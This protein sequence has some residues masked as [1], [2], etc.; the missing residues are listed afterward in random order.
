M[1][2]HVQ[3]P[4]LSAFQVAKITCDAWGVRNFEREVVD[5]FNHGFI[6]A[7]PTTLLLMKAVELQ[8]GRRA[9]HITH[10]I[11]NL[12]RLASLVPFPLEWIALRRRQDRR[13]RVYRMERF[14]EL[15]LRM[16][17]AKRKT[18]K[19]FRAALPSC[20][21]AFLIPPSSSHV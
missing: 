2:D 20:V 15:A 17:Q 13:L 4:G 7:T 19:D 5:H 16:N 1:I 21:P 14:L 12:A 10:A 18:G 9:W 11:G 8:D 6:Y 3:T